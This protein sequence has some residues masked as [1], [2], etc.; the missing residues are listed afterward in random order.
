MSGVEDAE[1]KLVRRTDAFQDVLVT[2]GSEAIFVGAR[3]IAVEFNAA[4]MA[5]LRTQLGSPGAYP[6]LIDITAC[7]DQMVYALSID[8]DVWHREAGGRWRP[9]KIETEETLLSLTCAPD[10]RL[11]AVGSFTTLVN[12]PDGG[13]SWK[14]ISLDEDAFLT[15]ISFPDARTG[16]AIGEFGA[17]L[18]STD[19]GRDWENLNTLPYDFYPLTSYFDTPQVGW[20]G[21]L[22]GAILV[23]RDGGRSWRK[24]RVDSRA[25]IYRIKRIA[26]RIYA[27]GN[28]GTILIYNNNQW[29]TADDIKLNSLGYL[30][31]IAGTKEAVYLGGQSL[32]TRI[33]KN[34]GGISKN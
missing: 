13:K 17:V 7:P 26:N 9:H 34:N 16:Y 8:G 11:W 3:G 15:G 30:R 4:G 5:H 2:S 1:E 24:Q 23:T 31:A 10:G 27:V 25:P 18:K 33:D 14:T 19:G 32:A 28:Y 12:S 6:D 29:V 22:D 21:G 20:V